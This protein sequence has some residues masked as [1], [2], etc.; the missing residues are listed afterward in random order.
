MTNTGALPVHGLMLVLISTPQGLS[1]V[2]NPDPAAP[3][4]GPMWAVLVHRF[5]VAENDQMNAFDS[6]TIPWGQVILT[7]L[8]GPGTGMP[9]EIAK[10]A[11]RDLIQ[12]AS[13]S[14][15]IEPPSGRPAPG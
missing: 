12:P 7:A 6:T 8:D 13:R 3:S 5:P 14:E 9:I 1:F 11:P 4:R 10:I 2:H 15:S